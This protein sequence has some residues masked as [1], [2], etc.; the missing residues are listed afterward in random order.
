MTLW[1]DTDYIMHGSY[2]NVAINK[3]VPCM[4]PKTHAVT[5]RKDE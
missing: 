4:M 3:T 5:T 2:E 1:K